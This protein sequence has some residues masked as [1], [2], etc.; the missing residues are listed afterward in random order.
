MMPS[1]AKRKLANERNSLF[2][3]HTASV[4][5]FFFGWLVVSS[6]KVGCVFLIIL[7]RLVLALWISGG[8]SFVN[9]FV[10]NDAKK[11]PFSLLVS[12][13][14]D[15]V[16]VCFFVPQ[17]RNKIMCKTPVCAFRCQYQLSVWLYF[18]QPP[19]CVFVDRKNVKRVNEMLLFI[20]NFT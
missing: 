5:S 1:P 17:I 11:Q 9:W 18:K 12:L 6:N 19:I 16:G 2:L 15:V 14:T 4:C 20:V 7:K 10:W 13:T 8:S 3:S